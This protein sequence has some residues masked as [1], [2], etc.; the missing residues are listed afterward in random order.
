VTVSRQ[1]GDVLVDLRYA[2]T[3]RWQPGERLD[4]LF[5]A[6]CDRLRGEGHGD[7][8]A[9]ADGDVVLTYD[10]L[11]ARANRLARH[12]SGE[13]VRA[14]DRI[15]LLF[16]RGIHAY[17][18][19]L[20]V[21]K[22][23]AA[24]VPL[25]AGFP[26]DR[27]AYIVS[28]AAVR[29][30]V[31]LSSLRAV[32]AR[33]D[34]E[35]L[36]VD[37]RAD[38]IAGEDD[39]RLTAV[40]RSAAVDELCYVV[41]TSGS[42]GRPKGVAIDHGGICSFVRVA[43]QV[44][45]LTGQDRVYQGMT[46]AFDFSVEEIWVP[47]MVGATLVP[48]PGGTALI[49][50]E[51]R[52]FLVEQR[53][54]AMCCVPTL[55]ATLEDD[56]PG[57][58]F[59][60]VSGEACPQDL[61]ARWYRPGRRFLNV[62]GPTESTVSA[63]WTTLHPDR[64]VTIG[65]PL[66]T[67]SVVILEPDA[68]Q[69]VPQGDVGE[70]GI[71]G[72]GLSR[73]YLNRPDLTALAFVEDVLNIPNN[74][75]GRIYRT[76]DLGRID[77]DGEV[78]YHGRIDTQVKIRGYRIELTEI[79]SVLLNLPGIAAAVVQ[80]YSPEP[81]VVELIAYY[82]R[83]G[84][85]AVDPAE[86]YQ[87]LTNHLPGYMVP[88]Y[89]E[90]LDTFPM[91]ASDKVDRKS[92]P[93]PH[94]GRRLASLQSHVAPSNPTERALADVLAG[95]L[96]VERVSAQ[97]HF[98]DELG[99]DSLLMARFCARVR[100]DP[101]LAALAMRD[102]YLNP[103]VERL[104]LELGSHLRAAD[105]PALS[106]KSENLSAAGGRS[107]GSPA[108]SVATDTTKYVLTGVAQGVFFLCYTYLAALGIELGVGWIDAAD[109]AVA[110]YLRTVEVG[111]LF[112]AVTIFL[113]IMTKW[114]LIGRWT[115]RDIPL[116]GLAYLRFWIVRTLTRISPAILFVGSPLYVLY[117]RALGARIG[118]RVVI[119][120]R[121]VPA[122]TDLLTIG[123]GS[124]IRKDAFFNGYRAEGCVIRTGRITLGDDAFVGE[125]TV[126]DVDTALGSGAQLG[127]SSALLRGQQVPDGQRWHGSPAQATEV[128]HVRVPSLPYQWS[129]SVAHTVEHLLTQLLVGLPL[130]LGAIRPLVMSLIPGADTA[131]QGLSRLPMP[132]WSFGLHLLA[133]T[134]VEFLAGLSVG[135]LLVMTLP[136]VL[137]L[138]L[139][140]DRVYPMYGFHY[141]L[142]RT[143]ARMT[144]IRLFT[145]LFGDSSYIVGYLASLGY[146][147]FPV[148]QT[149]SNFGIDVKHETPY[150]SGV[151]TGTMVSD[152]LS[153]MNAEYSSTSF[154]VSPA[155]VG[156]RNFIGNNVAF[157]AGSR[158]GDNCLLATKVL[159]PLDGDLRENV[160]LLGSP[161]FEIP[162]SVQRDAQFDHLK[163]GEEFRRRLAAKNRYNLATIAW[164]LLT[165]WLYVFLV[166]LLMA[167][168]FSLQSQLGTWAIA[169]ALTLVPVVSATYF[170]LLQHA[171]M[172]FRAMQPRYCSI[173]DRY[174]WRHERFWKL[175]A[176][177][178][179]QM[180]NGTPLKSW[181]WRA[182]GMR[183]GR[184]LFDDGCGIPEKSLVTIGD[185]CT[186]NQGGV[187]QGHSLED[188]TFK[189]DHISL[190]DGCTVG[191]K[192]FIHYGVQIGAGAV[193]EADSF[194]MK[195][196]EIPAR[197]RWQGNPA[198]PA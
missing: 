8:V 20:A 58:R 77:D 70:I 100:E 120:S 183:V 76:G 108:P 85:A 115:P 4:H 128:D 153:L 94:G 41:Y 84:D 74:P 190:G 12:L 123:A 11:D 48:K 16:D 171:V 107:G 69:S 135:L 66:P 176:S 117:L 131:G 136:R 2:Q 73:G 150:L 184:R 145:A 139:H 24:Y 5:E 101:Q 86:V 154:R 151:G 162:R 72:I 103:T 112:L 132:G 175:D 33:A 186:L 166:G 195:G 160:G 26:A 193:L 147:L 189:S 109:G 43:A 13:G 174:F 53:I 110:T 196:E 164:F 37:E 169:L 140:P 36:C 99:A 111:A 138:A 191:T 146:Q 163:T 167:G 130:T 19:M 92:L 192:A 22:L 87:K 105:A 197:R 182:L 158:T 15:G 27:V 57:L 14:G 180:F 65:V 56:L 32:L 7:R 156:A 51:L 172:G 142:Q 129:R 6:Q 143:I 21:L 31:S 49:G 61:V 161:P 122:C 106:T 90:E 149:G 181:I 165:R 134:L 59:L 188:G 71:A 29:T 30:V 95:V 39:G 168:A 60:L 55:L 179:V 137:N 93:A 25:D 67:Y 62:Y 141:S 52:D 80:P 23:N 18:G 125:A 89:L 178:Y 42:T 102:V 34:V 79:E 118:A 40:E 28:D 144:N 133:I 152:G 114:V 96:R 1:A 170:I 194:L 3:P 46:I 119:L 44:Y 75:P 47:W 173:Y 148:E 9:A 50:R 82:S 78:E 126:L 155:R 68:V 104:A 91:L 159:V 88:A 64:R 83:R 127:H 35:V 124:V 97:A 157:P 187:V 38:L 198:R 45:G 54:T 63:T 185:F 10:E 81:G 113:P 177:A 121:N 17:V 116:W 98:F